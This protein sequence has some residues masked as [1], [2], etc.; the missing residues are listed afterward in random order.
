MD[1]CLTCTVSLICS[2]RW[3]NMSLKRY[4][5]FSISIISNNFSFS[6]YLNVYAHPCSTFLFM[7]VKS[8]TVNAK[9]SNKQPNAPTIVDANILPSLKF[10]SI[11]MGYHENNHLRKYQIMQNCVNLSIY[12]WMTSVCLNFPFYIRLVKSFVS[13][14]AWHTQHSISKTQWIKRKRKEIR[15]RKRE[16]VKKKSFYD[17]IHK[18]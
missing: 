1:W 15:K 5:S 4:S 7:A 13:S 16:R 3:T 2:N 12:G 14:F 18:I 11:N 8:D 10:N 9:A 6:I 17:V